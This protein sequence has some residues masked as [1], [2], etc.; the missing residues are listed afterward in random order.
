MP[1]GS[2]KIPPSA[3]VEVPV[4][5]ARQLALQSQAFPRMARRGRPG[6]AAIVDLVERLGYLQLDPTTIVARSHLLVLWSRLGNFDPRWVDRLLEDDRLLF[7][8]WTHA[9]AIVPASDFVFHQ[10]SMRQFATPRP[11]WGPAIW[12]WLRENP[13][14]QREVLRRVREDGPVGLDAFEGRGRSG[15]TETTRTPGRNVD[16]MLSILWLQGKVAVTRRK[17]GRRVWD[18]AERHYGERLRAEK[19]DP[20]AGA[21]HAVERAMAALGVA[22][23]R[24]IS[25]YGFAAH[26]AGVPKAVRERVTE[27][28]LVPIS[29][30]DALVPSRN[31]WFARSEDLPFLLGAPA[32]KAWNRA[33]LLSPF[34]N[35]IAHRGRTEALFGLR[36]RIEIYTPRDQRVHGYYAPPVLA[37]DRIVG[38]V[39]TALNRATGQLSVHQGHRVPGGS[40]DEGEGA[41]VDRAVH[42]LARFVGARRVLYGARFPSEWSEGLRSGP[43]DHTS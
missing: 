42:S 26:F 21:G 35:L 13:Q 1:S 43:V 15:W 38:T 16:Q 20:M 24:M 37:G 17:S 12:K 23:A 14:L 27:G 40:A 5:R 30:R 39:E 28:R 10:H 22:D 7:E 34:D 8:Y 6:K 32:G 9:A 19:I 31:P 25:R 18:L 4:A 36:Y 11:G 2:P 29:L 41:S 3:I 33:T